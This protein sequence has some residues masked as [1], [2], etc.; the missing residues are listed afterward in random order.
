MNQPEERRN[1][2]AEPMVWLVWGIPGTAVVMGIAMLVFATVTYDGLVVDDYYKQGKNIN[3]VMHRDETARDMQL[4]ARLQFSPEA[5]AVQVSVRALSS[6]LP[7]DV[8]LTL[9]HATRN[10]MDRE[11][12]LRSDVDGAY[13]TQLRGLEPGR[14]YVSLGNAQWRLTGE[15]HAPIESGLSL[16]L[17]PLPPSS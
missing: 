2:Y 12:D 10:G 5:A 4:R 11:V 3:R 9:S 6:E 14:W 1:W 16:D 17:V 7:G 13:A 15:F 8:R